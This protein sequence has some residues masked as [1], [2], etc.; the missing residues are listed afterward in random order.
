MLSCLLLVQ[1]LAAFEAQ[2]SA[3]AW[4]YKTQQTAFLATPGVTAE[5]AA[6]LPK[7]LLGDDGYL[8][9]HNTIKAEL[10]AKA[11]RSKTVDPQHGTIQDT[12]T[13][14]EYELIMRTIMTQGTPESDRSLAMGTWAHS[15]VGRSDDVRLFYLSDLIAPQY[16]P[17]VG[18]R[19]TVSCILTAA[20]AS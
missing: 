18:E 8:L 16:I 12:Y 3:N 6:A 17:A 14:D 4:V 11:E 10:N 19:L 15:S 5:Q 13:P 2:H 7:S 1:S 20:L 9:I